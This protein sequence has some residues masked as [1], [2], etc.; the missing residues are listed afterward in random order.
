LYALALGIDAVREDH[1]IS[2]TNPG[3]IVF[4]EPDNRTVSPRVRRVQAAFNAVGIPY[5][6]PP[7]MNRALWLKF[8]INVGINA[9][10][11]VLNAPYGIF[12]SQPPARALMDAL[13]REALGLAQAVGVD[14]KQQDLE[15]WYHILSEMS[16]QGKT[17]M[18]QDIQAGR[19]TEIEAFQGK[20]VQLGQE[21]GL[22]TPVNQALLHMVQ[23]L[24]AS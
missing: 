4:G 9:P 8:M 23:V 2:Y 5:E 24:E 16:P 13:M 1:C 15:D 7:D 14:L 3:K 20:V 17:S 18:L 12:Q 6:T 10:S 11:A 19:K 22:S 21:H